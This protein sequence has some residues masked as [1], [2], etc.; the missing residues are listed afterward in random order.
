MLKPEPMTKVVICGLNQ[1]LPEVSHILSQKRLVHLEDYGGEDEGFL[2]GATLDYGAKV[3]EYLVR[4]RSLIKILDIDAGSPV[5]VRD[6]NSVE[7]EVF[8]KLDGL[9]KNILAIHENHRDSIQKLKDGMSRW[10]SLKQFE[11]FGINLESFS[12]FKSISVFT[13]TLTLPSKTEISIPNAEIVRRDDMVAVFVPTDSHEAVEQQLIKAGFKSLDSPT[14]EG[15]IRD[16]LS[17]LESEMQNL[18]REVGALGHELEALNKRH[19][20]W[21]VIAEEHFAAQ[22]EKSS[23]PLKLAMSKN[24]FV[25]DGWVPE[26][27]CEGL[28]TS[29]DGLNV[30][31]QLESSDDEPPVKLDNPSVVRPF[32]FFTKLYGIPKHR[33]LDPSALLFFGYPLFFGLMIGDLGYGFFYFLLGHLLVKKYGHS[34]ELLQLGKIIRL[35]GFSAFFFGTILFAEAF[36]FE[37]HMLNHEYVLH[38]SDSADVGFML[39]ATG[40][41]GLFY[42]TL[43][44]AMGFYNALNMHD[45]KHAVQEKFS[46]IMI[47]WGGLLF[48]PPWLFGNSLL[49]SRLGLSDEIE[50]W[51]GLAAF[52]VGL[53]LAVSA[54]GI[55]ALVEVPSVFVQVISY[56]R[57]AA[58]GV[59]DY[60]L[61]HAFNGMAFDIGFSGIS[62]I[63]ALLILLVGQMV[64]FTL[65]LIGSGINSLR[66]QYVEC[67]PKFFVGGGTDYTPF[68]YTRKYTHETETTA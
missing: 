54:E 16:E 4:I 17:A 28:E 58:L 11:P 13:G 24:A 7:E 39:L 47:L 41:I 12:G 66:L 40:G 25:L 49:G 56:V 26:K 1:D 37:I 63:P 23:L 48:I 15:I 64:V 31:I 6:A 52:L 10:E 34:D 68:G 14:G 62:I 20:Q 3:S 42:V 65:G 57:I 45:L 21:L 8:E 61:A 35:A 51:G 22:S 30:D 43:G 29:L 5:G 27:E 59:A 67:F 60:G 18:E 44:L 55:V 50:L 32:E 9:E 2:A 33:E 38:K 53:S 36:G 19:G 46:W